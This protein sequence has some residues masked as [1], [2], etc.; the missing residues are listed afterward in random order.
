MAKKPVKKPPVKRSPKAKAAVS[1]PV[2]ARLIEGD[3]AF[4]EHVKKSTRT[5]Q[6]WRD[7]GLPHKEDPP[8]S[9]KYRYNLDETE[10]W[11]AENI[12]K[13]EE[14]N[15]ERAKLRFEREKA[16]L[17]ADIAKALKVEREEQEAQ[18]NILL[19]DEWES[20]AIEQIQIARGQL[21]QLGKQARRHMCR[22]C[23]KTAP[24]EIEKLIDKAL[25]KI[26]AMKDGPPKE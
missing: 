12:S 15:N 6:T 24:A 13:D 10:A 5:I 16:K 7:K 4:A 1:K 25:R 18:G 23:Q 26:A 9:K 17:R 11:I 3:K 19:R 21:L 22:K 14:Q 20:F 8:G 2:A